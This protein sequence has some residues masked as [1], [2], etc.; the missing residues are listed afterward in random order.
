MVKIT[1]VNSGS[2]ATL[3][4]AG[5]IDADSAQEVQEHLQKAVERFDKLILDFEK[6]T[7]ISSAGLR[8]LRI[9]QRSMEKKAG[10]LV[11]RNV[12]KDVMDVFNVTGFSLIL[13]FEE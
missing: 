2:E 4:L 1:L 7:Y 10:S 13:D 5:R 6:V 9:V 11:I 3:L 12:R 8:V